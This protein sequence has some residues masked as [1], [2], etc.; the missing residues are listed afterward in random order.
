ML[1]RKS[2]LALAIGSL[3]LTACNMTP[4]QQD[5]LGGALTGA[6]VGIVTATL[7]DADRNWVI[8]AALAGAAVGTMVA[9]NR[10]TNQCA[11]A[12]GDGTYR[13]RRCPY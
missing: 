5:H 12:L 6:A 3:A 4:R 7:F 10:H 2:I 11:Y 8:L 13:L 1:I 9:R